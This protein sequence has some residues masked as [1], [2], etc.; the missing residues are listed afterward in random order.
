MPYRYRYR[1]FLKVSIYRQS[2]S[3]I[4]ISNRAR[5][6]ANTLQSFTELDILSKYH[7]QFD[8]IDIVDIV[9]W[10][11]GEMRRI[12]KDIQSQHLCWLIIWLNKKFR[13]ESSSLMK[14][15]LF[16]DC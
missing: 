3:D 10:L 8:T 2:I 4:D 7:L 1:Y 12:W 14:K 9:C 15:V 16:D 6:F 11:V 13:L 5:L